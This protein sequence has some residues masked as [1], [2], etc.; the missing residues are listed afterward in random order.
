MPWIREIL[1]GTNPSR[2]AE[3]HA[4]RFGRSGI[5]QSSRIRQELESWLVDES[6]QESLSPSEVLALQALAFAGPA[7]LDEPSV[8]MESL[9]LQAFAFRGEEQGWH[10]ILDW[11]PALRSRFLADCQEPEH[12]SPDH[13]LP[14]SRAWVEG[15]VA[16]GA[17]I[18]LGEA[19]L[20]RTSE[21]NRRQRPRLRES[22]FHLDELPSQAQELCLDL[23]L[24]FL[25][26]HDW[27]DERDGVLELNAEGHVALEDCELLESSVTRWWIRQA[28]RTDS[29]WW[30]QISQRAM[31]GE[32][33]L[34]IWGW[35]DS[36]NLRGPAVW[37]R[38]P[39][40][41][42]EAIALG[43]LE[44][45]V[46]H[47]AISWVGPPGKNPPTPDREVLVTAD[48]LAYLSPMSALPWRRS[49]EIA[50]R[51]ETSG[52]VSCYRFT[53]ESILEA[54]A[55]PSLGQE[56]AAFLDRLETPVS[57][58]RVLREWLESRRTCQFETL[59]IL[60]VRDASRFRE[61]AAL[62]SIQALVHEVIPDWGFV[63]DPIQEV[64]LRRELAALGY[65]PPVVSEERPK[66]K[67]WRSPETP[68][69]I[70]DVP[71]WRFD[72]PASEETKRSSVSANSKYGEGLKELPFQDL[73]RVIEYAI[74]TDAEVEVVLKGAS[75]KPLRIRILRLDKRHEPVSISFRTIGAREDRESPLEQVR[76]IRICP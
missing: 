57:V 69:I 45:V 28:F 56:L 55:H 19:K 49:L 34:R 3:I 4:Q 70:A 76:K 18:D 46:D 6:R 13:Q 2:I 64:Q 27:V 20:T 29:A 43:R 32:D 31:G 16:L 37:S 23:S 42:A 74:L 30:E 15:I 52:I 38:L 59:R 48:L 68:A 41:L 35:L 8:E 11:A 61:L 21:L 12:P 50:A 75:A 40:R 5:L 44:T 65:D 14:A 58:G 60:R 62:P 63:L 47:G 66:A 51:R 10:G 33:A 72:P 24:R 54:A 9:A 53:R 1:D 73:L 71:E 36:Q 67:L 25:S 39:P 22:F 17:R 26:D 7:G